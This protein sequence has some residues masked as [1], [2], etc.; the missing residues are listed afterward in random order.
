MAIR[1]FPVS[2]MTPARTTTRHRWQAGA[3]LAAGALLLTAC[4][5]SSGSASTSAT[6]APGA[7]TS[8][9]SPAPA[10]SATPMQAGPVMVSDQWAKAIPDI[11]AAKMTGVFGKLKNTTDK[12]ITIVSGTNSVS[13]LTE[14]HE[15]VMMDGSMKMR[16]VAGGFTIEPGQTRE[17]K[18]GSDHVRVMQMTKPLKVGDE[19]TLTLKTKEGQTIEFTAIA[20]AFTGA[21]ETYVSHTM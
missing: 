6:P 13:S 4:G 16:P 2:P 1:R 8:A 9:T 20:R 15:T 21:N 7:G 3:A 18:P 12:P 19:V 5:G 17:F 10:G 14:L 11:A